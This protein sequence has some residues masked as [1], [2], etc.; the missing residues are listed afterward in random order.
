M[1]EEWIQYKIL[2]LVRKKEE[3]KRPI[4]SAKI[5]A[6]RVESALKKDGSKLN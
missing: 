1:F 3:K 2:F 4:K 5:V 6:N